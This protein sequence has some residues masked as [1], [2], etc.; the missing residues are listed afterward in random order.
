[1][2]YS[3]E[4]QNPKVVLQQHIRTADLS[5]IDRSYTK[6]EKPGFSRTSLDPIENSDDLNQQLFDNKSLL[7]ILIS[8]IAMH[9]KE[10]TRRDFF[11]QIDELLDV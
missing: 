11:K 5:K 9:M 7:K 1:M 4:P 3:Y 2:R 6:E 8:R 10:E